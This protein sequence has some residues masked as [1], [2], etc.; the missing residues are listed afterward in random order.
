MSTK[1]IQIVGSMN[2]NTLGGKTA[3]EF[4]AASDV[5]QLKTLLGD[6]SVSEQISSAVEGIT[7][8]VDS[9]NGKTGVVQLTASD[10]GALSPE[11]EISSGKVIYG[12]A[13][14]LLSTLIETYILNIDYEKLLAFNTDEIVFGES[15]NA[16]TSSVLGVAVL[17]QMVLA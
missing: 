17:G 14:T 16:G 4:A 5:E 7:F 9:I 11:D 2:A 10:V 8:P 13:K 3:D 1:K 6:E 15:A 12:D